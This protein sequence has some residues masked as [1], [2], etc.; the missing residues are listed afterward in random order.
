MLDCFGIPPREY[1]ETVFVLFLDKPLH[2]HT[3]SNNNGLSVYH[4]VF[5]M[6]QIKVFLWCHVQQ[7]TDILPS[8]D[9]LRI[10]DS[11]FV[12]ILDE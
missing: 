1:W 12:G 3:V 8:L 10:H 7:P 6:E 9:I 5:F 2:N 4:R 11:N